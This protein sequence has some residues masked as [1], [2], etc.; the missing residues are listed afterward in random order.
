[1]MKSFGLPA[2]AIALLGC[3]AAPLS[4]QE[5]AGKYSL[6]GETVTGDP[7]QGAI[8]ITPRDQAFEIAWDRV[9]GLPH[10]GFA[11]RLGNVLGVVAEDTDE[12]YGVVLYRVKG[13]HLEGIWQGNLGAPWATLGRE[14]LDGPEGLDGN[15]VISLG[16]N[17]GGSHYYG[18][19]SIHRAGRI[20]SVNWYTEQLR[21]IGTGVLVG[22]IFVVGYAADH[23]SEVAAYCLRSV[24]A[25]DGITAD[26]TDGG[27]GAEQFWSAPDVNPEA[28]RLAALRDRDGR[29]GCGAPAAEGR[30]ALE[31]VIV[32]SR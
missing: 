23:R 1:M 26:I 6:R 3:A 18:K 8:T 14:D 28:A 24:N 17:P 10:R 9:E 31:P 29:F 30:P 21:Y 7:Y 12:D 19:V 11:L 27:L 13:G 15:F 32:T 16:L 20:Y 22:D 25:G 4:A 5:T 2:L